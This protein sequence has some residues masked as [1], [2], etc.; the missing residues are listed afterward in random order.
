VVPF[1]RPVTVIGE[2]T[3]P[4][5]TQ[6]WLPG[7]FFMSSA[8][9]V[10]AYIIQY[11]TEGS[12]FQL[13]VT[14]LPPA[15]TIKPPTGG[16]EELPPPPHELKSTASRTARTRVQKEIK[17]ICLIKVGKTAPIIDGNRSAYLSRT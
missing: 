2:V 16:D 13:T 8:P 15:V 10:G 6:T 4:L 9:P 14:W 1:S 17:D 11:V 3:A 7:G 5:F 12:A